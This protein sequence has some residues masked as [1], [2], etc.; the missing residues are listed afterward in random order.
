MKADTSRAPVSQRAHT[1]DVSK[2]GNGIGEK[3]SVVI[4]DQKFSVP[5]GKTILEAC[6]ENQI[7][8]PTL[9]HHPDLCIAGTC[10][11]CVVDVEGM[12]TLQTACSF[13]VTAPIKVKTSSPM[14]RKARRHILDLLLSEHYGECYACV[15]NNNCELQALAKEY[16]VDQYTF[17][18][19]T[20][21]L[22]DVDRSSFSVHRDIN[23]CVLCKRC[24]RTCIDLQ[25]VGVLE[26]IDRGDKTHIST[27][28]EKPLADV[29][30]IN[31]GQCINRCPTGAL[32]ANDPSDQVWNAIDDPKKHV[33]IQTAPSPRAAIGEVFGQE[34]GKS[35]TGEL[36]TALR[37][38]GFDKVFDTNFTADLTIL[39]EGT[40]LLLR[41]YKALVKKENISLPQFTSCSPG[42]VKYLEHFY[43]EHIDNLSSAKSPQQ[44]F[45]ALIKTF[46]AKEAGIN[47]ED[48]VCVALMPCAAKKFE[49]NRPEMNDSGYKDVDFGL[50]TREMGQMIKE[51]GIHLPEVPQSHFD[52]PFGDASGAGLIFG[53]T[54]GVMEA[55]LR[56]VIELVTGD[57]VENIFEHANITPVRGFEGIRYVEFPITKVGPVPDLLKN[58]V[59]DWNWLKGV[60]LKIAVAHGTANAKKIMEDIKSGGKFSECHFIEFMACPGG[61]LG[62]GGQPIPTTEEI[63]KKRAQAIYS[64]DESLPVRK[65]HENE[66]VA[67]LYDKFLTDGPGGHLSHKLLHTH[68]TKR[69]KYIA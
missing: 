8:V 20:E 29:V 31:C 6:R 58:L 61:C 54:G 66:H 57:K 62:G 32:R 36:N 45:G 3:I 63:R 65:S 56:T 19:I 25:E 48:I 43:P 26:A 53:A 41:L 69:G 35:Y 14:V 47:P 44:M 38:I 12:R 49:C 33:V 1:V 15:R 9:C 59:P 37:R 50:T 52:N 11:I 34:P 7:H 23:K 28:M 13:P 10:R 22:Y 5:F 17:G 51:A 18:H 2:N 68:Y 64:E 40:E 46:Y 24:V 30:C 21:P 55:A 16:G 67:T 39:E 42:W 60:T 27:F 4:N